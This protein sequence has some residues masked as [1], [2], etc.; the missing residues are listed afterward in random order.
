MNYDK[1]K[2]KCINTGEEKDVEVGIPLTALI[3]I[4]GVK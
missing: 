4:F 3:D 2:V 1:V